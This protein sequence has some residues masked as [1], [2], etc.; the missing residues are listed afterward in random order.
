MVAWK[1]KIN[2]VKDEGRALYSI[3]SAYQNI[4]VANEECISYSFGSAAAKVV[5]SMHWVRC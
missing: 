3:Y 1:K 2:E 4:D 5:H